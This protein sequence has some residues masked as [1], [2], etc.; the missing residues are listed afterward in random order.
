MKK[1]ALNLANKIYDLDERVYESVGS[2]LGR[3][4]IG[5]KTKCIDKLSALIYSNPHGYTLRS[6]VAL[7]G[8]MARTIQDKKEKS[9]KKFKVKRSFGKDLLLEFFKYFKDIIN[10]VKP[11]YFK[12]NGVFMYLIHLIII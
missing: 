10:I 3:V 5:D 2:E 6:E 4:F 9:K 12:I 11:K 8:N 7:V 1:T